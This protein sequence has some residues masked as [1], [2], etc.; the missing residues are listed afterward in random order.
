MPLNIP[1]SGNW[2]NFWKGKT[3]GRLDGLRTVKPLRVAVTSQ[4]EGWYLGPS[5]KDPLRTTE[6]V[7]ALFG[8]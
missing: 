7:L 3:Q 2:S 4:C 8:L 6:T 1:V 5:G